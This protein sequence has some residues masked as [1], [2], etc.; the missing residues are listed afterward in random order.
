MHIERAT[1][2]DNGNITSIAQTVGDEYVLGANELPPD[3][4]EN[5]II[6]SSSYE[7]RYYYDN[8]GQLVRV[9]DTGAN[10][11]VEFVYNGTS[12]NITA[13]KTYALSDKDAEL[14]TPL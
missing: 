6:V 12:G 7:K 13:I 3:D 14:G 9:D 2:D 1:Y 4:F 5:G 8:F 10:Q 11:T